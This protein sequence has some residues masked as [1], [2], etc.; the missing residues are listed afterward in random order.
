[1]LVLA[2][3]LSSPTSDAAIKPDLLPSVV[4]RAEA[5]SPRIWLNLPPA[6]V[7]VYRAAA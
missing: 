1:M 5:A 3:A 7:W 2:L 6:R 4:V